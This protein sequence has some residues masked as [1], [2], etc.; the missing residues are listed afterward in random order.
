MN[1]FHL[2]EQQPGRLNVIV[3]CTGSVASI[4]IPELLM[5]LHQIG[6]YNLILL[7]SHTSLS[8]FSRDALPKD[9]LVL[10]DTMEWKDYQ[11]GDPILHIELRK[12]VHLLLVAP[13]SSHTLA[14]WAA[15]MSD[16]LLLEVLRAWDYT[17]SKALYA[18]P[19]M[20]TAMFHHPITA[21]QL[22]VLQNDL[23]VQI[24]G[25]VEKTLACG[26]VG[27]GAMAEVMTLALAID[28]EY[29]G[30]FGSSQ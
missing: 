1:R 19:A 20:N 26:D 22:A 5:V 16:T 3:G 2:P 7:P 13:L 25:P 12:W 29:V 11:R 24:I 27:I 23:Q 18:A 10:D 8:F 30:R 6:R 21:R 15:G 17:A 14:K 28:K 4:K 9:V